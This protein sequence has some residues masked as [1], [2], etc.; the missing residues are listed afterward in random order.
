MYGLEIDFEGLLVLFYKCSKHTRGIQLGAVM[1]K[2]KIITEYIEKRI[3]NGN[4]KNGDKLPSENELTMRF[5]VSRDTVRRGFAILEEKG[6]I[7]RTRG[8]GTYVNNRR[9]QSAKRVAVVTTYVENYIFPKI[10][11][12]I[13]EALS[14]NGY[15]MQLSFTNNLFEKEREVLEDILLMNDIAGVIMEPVKSALPNPNLDSYRRLKEKGIPVLFI[16]SYYREVNIPHVSLNDEEMGYV[17]TKYLLSK[18]HKKIGAVLKMDDGQG[19]LRFAGFR[20][21]MYESGDR[22]PSDSVVWYDTKDERD[23]SKISDHLNERLSD[24]TAVFC[25]NDKTARDYI[26]FLSKLG[27][28]VPEDVS[29]IS[30]DDSMLASFQDV[31]LTS[32]PHPMEELGRTAVRNLLELIKNP[33][34]NAT[35]EFVTKVIERDSVKNISNL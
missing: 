29:V 9:D 15:V 31:K 33:N 10:I 13:E 34:A 21:A 4:L 8:S 22:N 23:I 2:Y 16:N 28:K 20:R 18:G 12:G 17:A 1:E 30:M 11:T 14:R 5:D 24:C 19:H 6:V 27:K 25:Y 7:R 26:M 3:E 35:K 32:C